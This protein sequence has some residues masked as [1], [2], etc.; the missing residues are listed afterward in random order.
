MVA[1]PETRLLPSMLGGWTQMA[2]READ[3]SGRVDHP[4]VSGFYSG[5]MPVWGG[6]RKIRCHGRAA[7]PPVTQ[8]APRMGRWWQD[9]EVLAAGA[10]DVAAYL[11]DLHAVGRRFAT[12]TR[13]RQPRPWTWLDAYAESAR[14]WFLSME[15]A[16]LIAELCRSDAEGSRHPQAYAKIEQWWHD[17]TADDAEQ[18]RRSTRLAR[19]LAEALDPPGAPPSLLDSARVRVLY[20]QRRRIN[21]LHAGLV[22]RFPTL[23]PISWLPVLRDD[24]GAFVTMADAGWA[25]RAAVAFLAAFLGV[26]ERTIRRHIKKARRR[27]N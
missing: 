26:D 9:P 3:Q 19:R 2:R 15:D 25:R 13:R 22:E 11:Q 6:R 17:M 7:I 10:R 20:V 24:D 18:R 8:A 14:F 27:S 23:P 16:A 12:N 1:G 4:A 5:P 21:R